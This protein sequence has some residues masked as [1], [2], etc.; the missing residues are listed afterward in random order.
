MSVKSKLLIPILS[1][2]FVGIAG[3]VAFFYFSASQILEDEIIRGIERNSLTSVKY[4]DSWLGERKADI[5]NW[6]RNRLYADA[7][8][9]SKYAVTSAVEVLKQKPKDYPYYEGVSLVNGKGMIIASSNPGH[10]GK[11]VR[12]REYFQHAMTGDFWLS[13]PITSKAT[14]E[15]VFV[16]AMPVRDF[17]QNMLGVMF[18]A[19]K[20]S[21]LYQAIIEPI[22]IG[23][24]GYAFIINAAG[25][26]LAHPDPE[27]VKTANDISQT[28]FGRYM[29]DHPEG[30]TYRYYYAPQKQ[31]KWLSFRHSQNSRWIIAVTAPLDE[32][33]APLRRARTYII[34]TGMAVLLLI[35]VLVWRSVGQMTRVLRAAASNLDKIARGDISKDMPE[36]FLRAKDEFGKMARAFQKMVEAQRQKVELAGA[37]A[38]G[39]LSRE[40]EMASDKDTLGRVLE[41]M[42]ATMRKVLDQVNDTVMRLSAGADQVS[43]SSQ[44]LSQGAT[45]QAA[46]LEE[47][48]SSMVELSSQTRSNAENASQARD[49]SSQAMEKAIQGSQEMSKMVDAMKDISESSRSIAKIINVI[50]EIAFQ[51]NILA[52]NAAVEA[53]RAGK[54]GKGFAV[55]ADEVRKLASR[56]AEAAKETA[57]LIENASKTVQTGDK[58]ADQTDAALKEIL[59]HSDKAADRVAQIASASDEQARGIAEINSGLSQIEEVTQR[60]TAS[61]EQTAAAAEELSGQAELLREMISFFKFNG[62]RKSLSEPKN[63]P[64]KRQSASEPGYEL[65]KAPSPRLEDGG[66]VLRPEDVIALDDDE[67]GRY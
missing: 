9:G 62:T 49:L 26:T 18:G 52:L 11:D 13:D 45:E 56:S 58:L 29:L 41:K 34:L 50:D 6:S 48:S 44:A 55:V 1:V 61:A 33:M 47:I 43:D 8:G 14:G 54:Y 16:L 46:S 7:L 59:E 15:Q 60:N 42:S 64:R 30:G 28:D 32:L 65:K 66:K 37:I 22:R 24:H 63:K 20:L 39:D 23:E 4:M 27:M 51:T 21:F 31:W 3:I 67:F 12:D 35:G 19:V 40:V 38:D 17:K 36:R 57:E 5:R 10:T 53:A 25:K 2:V